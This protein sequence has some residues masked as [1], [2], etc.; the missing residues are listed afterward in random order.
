MITTNPGDALS[1]CWKK[2]VGRLMP[3][4]FGDVTVLR[5]TRNVAGVDA[6]RRVHG[7]RGHAG[8]VRRRAALW[9]RRAHDDPRLSRRAR[10]RSRQTARFAIPDPDDPSDAWSWTDI[11]D[12]LEAV[13]KDPVA[14]LKNA[15]RTP[16]GR[17]RARWM[18]RTPRWN[19]CS[20]CRSGDSRSPATCRRTPRRSSSR[21]CRR[22][23]TTPVLQRDQGRGFH[24]GLLDGLE[25]FYA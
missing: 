21:R 10:S 6:D 2:R 25:G 19:W 14:A 16:I 1:R 20:T 22:S 24:G 7:A 8:R 4:A 18:R 9:R 23:C 11:T 17:T 3:G 12:R 5:A 15:R 13:G